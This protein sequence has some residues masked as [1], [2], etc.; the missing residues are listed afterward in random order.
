MAPDL[1]VASGYDAAQFDRFAIKLGQFAEPPR[2][3]LNTLAQYQQRDA[4]DQQMQANKLQMMAAQ[5]T[6]AEKQR[7][8][9]EQ[10][11]LRNA[12]ASLGGTGSD[13]DRI[14]AAHSLGTQTGYSYADMMAKTLIERQKAQAEIS[15]K[16]AE[17]DHKRALI[18]GVTQDQSIKAHEEHLKALPMFNTPELFAQWLKAGVD[19]K[20]LSAD[21]ASALANQIGRAHV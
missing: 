16:N 15:A 4:A 5:Q 1:I 2:S 17:A 6:M 7:A 9:Q 11:Q 12:L 20:A 3:M 21:G 8:L 14:R 19:N 10:D 18:P 13:E